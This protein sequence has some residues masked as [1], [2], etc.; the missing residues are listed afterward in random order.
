MTDSM[1]DM[2]P[3]KIV[4]YLGKDPVDFTRNDLIKFMKNNGIEM[5]NFRYPGGDGRLKTLNFVIHSRAQLERL[6]SSGR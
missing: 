3:N 2:N 4:S 6:L 1:I 5:V